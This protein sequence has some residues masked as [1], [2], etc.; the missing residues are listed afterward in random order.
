[1]KLQAFHKKYFCLR[2]FSSKNVIQLTKSPFSLT[3]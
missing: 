3:A 1:L 2:L